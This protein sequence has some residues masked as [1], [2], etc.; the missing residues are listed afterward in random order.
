MRIQK[1][2]LKSSI[3]AIAVFA[4]VFSAQI[5]G[6][7]NWADN[8]S[9]DSRMKFTARFFSP[10]E[11][12][13]VVLLDQDS[14]DWAK[15]EM[16]WGWPWPREAYGKMVDFFNRGNADS[17]AFDMIFTEQSVYGKDDDEKFAEACSNSGK[18]IQTVYYDSMT[19][20]PL[21]PVPE[22]AD[23]AAVLANI[24]SLLDDDGVTRRARFYAPS[25]T[26]EP[27]LALA[28]LNVAEKE[29]IDSIPQTKNGGMYIRYL[30]DLTRY[31]PYNAKQILQNEYALEQGKT[32][33]E[34][35]TL[36]CEQFEGMHVF[37]GLFSPGLFD[38]CTS[39]V[40]SVYPGVGVHISQL[41]TILQ[42]NYLYDTPSSATLVL[43]IIAAIL[44]S[45]LGAAKNQ[46]QIKSFLI[47]FGIFIIIAA[48]Y[49]FVLYATFA[50]GL[51][52]PFGSPLSALIISFAT[53][54]ILSYLTEGKQRRYLKTA[55]KQ[56]LSPAVIEELIE[57]PSLLKLGG[58]DREITAF[59]SDVQG[60][61]SI[62]E[63]LTPEELTN[64][65][66]TYLSA[67]SDIILA[68]GGTIDKYEGDAIIAFWGAPSVQKD[69]AKRAL[70]AAMECQKKL[71]EMRPALLKQSGRPM[72]H[73]IG[74]NTGHAVV[75][76]MGSNKRFDYTMLGDTVNLASRL[77]GINKQ[78]GTYTMC[79]KATMDSAIEN[80]CSLAFRKI[81]DIAV[82]GRKEP[83]C[84]YEPMS[85][86]NN[87]K[88]MATYTVFEK[89]LELFKEG[90]FAAASKFFESV[91][92]EDPVAV[93]Y[94]E[95][96]EKL[97]QNPPESWQ[98][99]LQATEK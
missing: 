51:I 90:D 96:C 26:A 73:R 89:G 8:K 74:L 40:S 19:D 95:K 1:K 10:S 13:A 91:A 99:F 61:T 27:C 86:E 43:I 34:E 65:L 76:N 37:F 49:L 12:I 84:T 56:Y 88:M 98:G 69:H 81:A 47:Q 32:L 80:G 67:M 64:L 21:L 30:N 2:I 79:S 3:T 9:Y 55:F 82:V 35:E 83:V 93:K 28:S 97:I 48:M 31:A 41:D 20:T 60:F 52:L 66:N 4:I 46:V 54:V 68:H 50:K 71:E 14:L 57:N 85:I 42:N 78:F 17:V 6:V 70:E 63:K 92:Q 7:F 11:E 44:G 39:P 15:R 72:Y 23:S 36:D 94:K 33:S 62:S 24:T 58:E 29:K 18:V 87:K 5:S 75:G 53:S 16:N 59:F 22:I 45:I 38:I 77:E 25:K